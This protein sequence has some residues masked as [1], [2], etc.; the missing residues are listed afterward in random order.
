MKSLPI[1]ELYQRSPADGL[2]GELSLIYTD[3]I[4]LAVTPV[5]ALPSP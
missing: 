3:A 5:R 1:P 4:A 2:A